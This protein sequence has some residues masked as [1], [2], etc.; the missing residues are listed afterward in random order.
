MEE[1]IGENPKAKSAKDLLRMKK[2]ELL[3]GF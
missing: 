1:A 2:A 3:S